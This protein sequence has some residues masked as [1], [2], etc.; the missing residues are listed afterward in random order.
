MNVYEFKNEKGEVMPTFNPEEA[1]SLDA[2][3]AYLS[4]MKC[5]RTA[6][7]WNRLRKQVKVSF[8]NAMLCRLDGSGFIYQWLNQYKKT[9]ES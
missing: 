8:G 2:V 6:E 9:N 1:N 7:E 3:K 4:A 5:A